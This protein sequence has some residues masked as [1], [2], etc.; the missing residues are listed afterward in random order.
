MKEYEVI[1][2]NA[3]FRKNQYKNNPLLRLNRINQEI[4]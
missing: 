2:L 4:F 3:K 1:S